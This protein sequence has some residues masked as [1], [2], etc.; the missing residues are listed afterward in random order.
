M[1]GNR[2]LG[3]TFGHWSLS[4]LTVCHISCGTKMVSHSD[5]SQVIWWVTNTL[6]SLVHIMVILQ[7][8]EIS[9]HCPIFRIEKQLGNFFFIFVMVFLKFHHNF[10]KISRLRSQKSFQKFLSIFLKLFRCSHF[11]RFW[12]ITLKIVISLKLWL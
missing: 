2:I 9:S 11:L 3:A 5:M 7:V 1:H 6:K 4:W 8:K 12:K 10:F